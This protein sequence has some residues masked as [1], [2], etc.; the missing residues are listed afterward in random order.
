MPGCGD[1]L[2]RHGYTMTLLDDAAGDW[3]CEPS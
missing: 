1:I 2:R 3:L